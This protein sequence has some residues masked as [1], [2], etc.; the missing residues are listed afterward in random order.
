MAVE[1]SCSAVR[2]HATELPR[3]SSVLKRRAPCQDG[4]HTRR[5]SGLPGASGLRCDQVGRV[6]QMPVWQPGERVFSIAHAQNSAQTRTGASPSSDFA[7]C[8]LA[9]PRLLL[10]ISEFSR[11]ICASFLLRSMV[12]SAR[13]SEPYARVRALRRRNACE[14]RKL[15]RSW[16]K[17]RRPRLRQ[18]PTLWA[19]T[20]VSTS[21]DANL[22]ATAKLRHQRRRQVLCITLGTPE[23]SCR[24]RRS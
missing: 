6:E 7:Q 1:R 23:W 17:I 3:I 14:R 18:E 11:F 15:R 16:P 9:L 21:K 12:K 8:L 20:R 19:N 24:R 5:V 10:F 4:K 13:V 22:R 2:A